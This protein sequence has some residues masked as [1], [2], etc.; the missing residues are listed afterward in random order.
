MPIDL[1]RLPDEPIIVVTCT[2]ELDTTTLQDMF[3]QTLDW[4]DEDEALI[5]RIVD[6]HAVTTSFDDVLRAARE[7]SGTSEPGSTVDPR[8][9]PVMVGGDECGWRK[10]DAPLKVR[11]SGVCRFRCTTAWRIALTAIRREIK[12]KE[13]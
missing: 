8:I 4:M 1:H 13:E 9:K 10:P 2:R 5:Y 6:Y 7:A 3:A 12:A 11:L